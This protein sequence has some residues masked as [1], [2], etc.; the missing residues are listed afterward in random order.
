MFVVDVSVVRFDSII[1]PVECF[2]LDSIWNRAL[3]P[4]RPDSIL[5]PD[6]GGQYIHTQARRYPF[7]VYSAPATYHYNNVLCVERVSYYVVLLELIMIPQSS[8][9]TFSAT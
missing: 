6:A 2:G 1:C 9:L 7:Q 8:L 3:L 4:V 5:K